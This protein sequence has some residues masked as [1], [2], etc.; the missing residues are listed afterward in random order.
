MGKPCLCIAV[1]LRALI[2]G[3]AQ[4]I[5]NIGAFLLEAEFHSYRVYLF[6]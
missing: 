5:V 1:P 3:F 2:L 6:P 4:S